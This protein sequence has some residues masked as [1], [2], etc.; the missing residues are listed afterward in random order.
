MSVSG[1]M[2]GGTTLSRWVG[3]CAGLALAW[4]GVLAAEPVAGSLVPWGNPDGAG[5]YAAVE[6]LLRS[7]VISVC[8][9]NSAMAALKADGSVVVWGN[10]AEG[11]NASA[12]AA[13]LA[14]GVQR[15]FAGPTSFAALKTGGKV[16]TWGDYSSDTSSAGNQLDSGVVQIIPGQYAF[17]GI[18]A[19]GSVVA[20]GNSNYGGNIAPVAGLLTGGVTKIV[21]VGRKFAALRTDGAVVVWGDQTSS[22]PTDLASGVADIVSNGDRFAAVKA[23][24]SAVY[25]FSLNSGD[26]GARLA[27]GV[28]SIVAGPGGMTAFKQNGETVSW[29]YVQTNLYTSPVITGQIQK[30]VTAP[31]GFAVLLADG[32]VQTWRASL[33]SGSAPPAGS[34]SSGVVDVVGDSSGFLALKSDGSVVAWSASIAAMDAAPYLSSVRS[35]H[36]N[37]SGAG[38]AVLNDGTVRAWGVVESGGEVYGV[39][40]ELAQGEIATVFP[41]GTAFAALVRTPRIFVDSPDFLEN[42]APAKVDHRLSVPAGLA[43]ETFTFALAAGTGDSGNPAFVIAGDLLR[44]AMPLDF[45]TRPVATVR[46]R[47]QGSAGTTAEHVLHLRILNDF[48]DDPPVPTYGVVSFGQQYEGG[49]SSSAAYGLRAGVKALYPSGKSFTAVKNDGNVLVWGNGETGGEQFDV[50]GGVFF[51]VKKVVAASQE[52]GVL[53]V[54]GAV[55]TWGATTTPPVHPYRTVMPDLNHGVV[56][57]LTTGTYDFAARTEDGQVFAWGY[58]TD[59]KITEAAKQLMVSGCVKMVVSSNRFHFLTADGQVVSSHG[60][61]SSNAGT[62][63]LLRSGIVDIEPLGSG[64]LA[65]KSDGSRVAWNV[66]AYAPSITALAE[67]GEIVEM[68]S[69][70]PYGTAVLLKNGSVTG[71]SAPGLT[72]GVVRLFDNGSAY[73]AL[74]QDGSVVVWGDSA[75]G[76]SASGVDLSSGVAEVIPGSG[77]FAALK[78]NG[79]VVAW[80]WASDGGNS[81]SVAAELASGV[82]RVV[83]VAQGFVAVKSD[84]TLVLWGDGLASVNRAAL[85]AQIGGRAVNVVTVTN[86]FGHAVLV[87]EPPC[88]IAWTAEPL[89]ERAAGGTV[90]GALSVERPVAGETYRF[91]LVSGAGAR[92][93]ASFRIEGDLVRA[94]APMDHAALPVARIRVRLEGDQGSVAERAI[95]IRIDDG[96]VPESRPGHRVTTWGLANAGGSSTTVA[97]SLGSGVSEVVASE[98]S[99]LALKTDGSVVGWGGYASTANVPGLTS[100]V[101]RLV[102][103]STNRFAALKQNGS[104]IGWGNSTLGGS[105]GA[106]AAN[107]QDGV[108]DIVPTQFAFAALKSDGSVVTWGSSTDG[109]DSSTVAH[110]LRSGVVR[111]FSN[112]TAFAALKW[113]GSVVTWGGYSSGGNSFTAAWKLG[114]SV[115]EVFSTPESFAALRNDGS[116]VTWGATYHGGGD[117]S[118]VA[119]SLA[120][121]VATVFSNDYAFAALKENGSVVTWGYASYGGNSSSVA[122]QLSSGVTRIISNKYCFSALKANGSL[123]VWGDSSWGGSPGSAAG[124][125]TSGVVDV[126]ATESAFAALKSNGSVVAWGYSPNGGSTTAVASSLTSGVVGVTGAE[127]AFAAVK[128]NGSVVTWGVPQW[129]GDSSAVAA[130]LT[131]VTRVAAASL[132]FAALSPD[133]A[134]LPAT[135]TVTEN[136]ATGTTVATLTASGMKAGETAVFSLPASGQGPGADRFR[137]SQGNKLVVHQALDHELFPVTTLRIVATGSLGTVVE[138]RL[139]L[140]ITDDVSD[141]WSAWLDFAGLSGGLRAAGADPDGDGVANA[142]EFA[143]G[144]NPASAVPTQEP[145]QIARDSNVNRISYFRNRAAS[146]FPLQLQYGDGLSGWTTATHGSGGVVIHTYFDWSP[147][148]DRVVVEIPVSASGKFFSRLVAADP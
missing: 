22:I 91:Q 127:T 41:A 90:A 145:L 19:D 34:L 113:D 63:P 74:K 48:K 11:G 111:I 115:V 124:S 75:R 136:A 70:S 24:G 95:L 82:V 28:A 117:S 140:T 35:L 143:T 122:S 102:A 56:E 139:A 2:I 47:A 20:W 138:T 54:H 109:G 141:N 1:W 99:F 125:L 101:T 148:I 31:Y 84:G 25:G 98:S 80:G 131:G 57:L 126:A 21:A 50:P 144:S 112:D 110:R 72:S 79:S 133:P 81:S 76:G 77:R 146:S 128:S 94:L 4:S 103:T 108:V 65:T 92:D 16:V 83:A 46:V 71:S 3:A 14:S 60:F 100:G 62:S 86:G 44:P 40:R 93:N 18:K 7:G 97:A 147:G 9:T 37:N 52:V 107:L 45:E 6:P 29:S 129:G 96:L 17:A 42:L 15:L 88:D 39:K 66:I 67:A 36:I 137:I 5:D 32:S 49:D 69:V 121:G 106:S 51:G 105:L 33:S 118:A 135:A 116:V 85:A 61:D 104:V 26:L 130:Q 89:A 30:V 38:C 132:A 53:N 134:I 73:A 12:V 13:D 55:H 114:E 78:S 10:P 59:P 123:V 68:R 64:L 120:S 8:A 23:D 142:I 27:S 58:S 43:G 87:E 119:D